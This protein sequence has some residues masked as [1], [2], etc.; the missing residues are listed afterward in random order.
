MPRLAKRINEGCEYPRWYGFAYRDWMRNQAVC[1]PL[2]L[3]WLAGL[4]HEGHI[5]LAHGIFHR[6]DKFSVALLVANVE[7]QS[8]GIEI[9]RGWRQHLLE[10]AFER[11]VAEG[12]RQALAAVEYALH[13][14][15]M[16]AG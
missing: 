3:N 13:P 6:A 16:V 14:R 5:R 1:Y 9:E 15:I 11:G 8:R 7:G 4:L 10:Q 12:K 2:G